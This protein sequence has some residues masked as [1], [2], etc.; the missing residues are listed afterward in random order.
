[1]KKLFVALIILCI[2]VGAGAVTKAGIERSRFYDLEQ[3]RTIDA[4]QAVEALKTKRFILVGEHHTTA[5]HHAAQL[6]VIRMLHQSGVKVAV[7]LE[8]FRSDSQAELDRWI[9]GKTDPEAFEYVYYDNWNYAWPLY[10][11][12]FE[13]ARENSIPMI[14]LN[15][16]R[17]I[18]RQVARAG[19]KS[20]SDDQRRRLGDVACRVD[21]EYMEFIRKA[22]GGHGHGN[23]SFMYFC[24]AQMVWDNAMAVAA[25]EYI[26]RHPDRVVV[27]LAGSGHVRKQAIPYQIRS[28]SSQPFAVILPEVPGLMDEQT[29][30]SRD[31]DLIFLDLD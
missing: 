7:G 17:D 3:N 31:A 16:P 1:M 2:L 28:R 30:D 9:A 6:A 26:E 20:L 21:K 29:L 10:R 11:D 12:I 18:T 23:M 8:M 22:Y 19:Y 27:I 14:G 4:R 15:V 25:L 24:E 13:Y 5:S